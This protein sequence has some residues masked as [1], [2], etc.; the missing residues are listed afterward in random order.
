MNF[1]FCCEHPVFTLAGILS[2]WKVARVIASALAELP[3]A[4]LMVIRYLD[5]RGSDGKVRKYRV[6]MIDGQLYPL[7]L[8]ISS[9]WKIHYFTAEMADHPQ[10]RAEDAEFLENMPGVLGSNAMS[11]LAQIQA[12]LG[13][14]YAGIDFG[15][16][17]AGEI[18]LFEANA[19]MVVNP[20]EPDQRWS[21]RRPAVERIYSAVRGML[22]E[23]A[24]NNVVQ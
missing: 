12:M 10:H 21:Y 16:N 15:L 20:P 2:W 7:H 3:G 5:A 1:P 24:K 4:N 6:M 9:D 22:M 14:E 19:T 17:A 18:L 11:A 23:R 8:A 13:L